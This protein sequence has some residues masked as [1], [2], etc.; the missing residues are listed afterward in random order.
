MQIYHKLD[1]ILK[2]AITK[3]SNTL[4]NHED[5]NRITM[6]LRVKVRGE[7]MFWENLSEKGI[8]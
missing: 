3:K 2:F 4:D 7:Q 8:D 1:K 5:F 6:G